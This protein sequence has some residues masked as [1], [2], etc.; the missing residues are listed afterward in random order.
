MKKPTNKN[1]MPRDIQNFLEHYGFTLEHVNGDHFIY[2]YPRIN[3]NIMLN[4]P[5]A[6]PVKPA[7]IDQIR[8]TILEIEEDE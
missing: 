1:I 2:C 6:K 5:M 7:Y 8:K 3:K 4:I